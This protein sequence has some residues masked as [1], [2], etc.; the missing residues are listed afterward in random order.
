MYEY[1]K[2]RVQWLDRLLATLLPVACLC[3][4]RIL[5]PGRNPLLLCPV[6]MGRMQRPISNRCPRCFQSPPGVH[7]CGEKRG[8]IDAIIAPWPY[9]PPLDAV[10]QGLKF[11]RLD[12]LG[13]ALSDLLYDKLVDNLHGDETVTAIPLHPWRR[14]RR[15]FDQAE[16]IARPLADRLGLP[17]RSLLRR[18]RWTKPQTRLGRKQR[19]SNLEG[20]FASRRHFE[21]SVLLVDDVLTTGA[22]V[23][24]AA[25]AL[26]HAGATRIVVATVAA[27]L[28]RKGAYS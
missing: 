27:T 28:S 6:C 12:Y 4:S 17:Y 5:E 11:K 7:S 24:A 3:C 10:L 26:R 16:C 25:L 2:H 14:L 19:R 8:P 15:G 22:T 18:G 23:E 1:R 21:G 9:A 20:A 13:G